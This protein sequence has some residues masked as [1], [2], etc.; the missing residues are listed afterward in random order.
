MKD[1]E[2]EQITDPSK[3]PQVIHGTY[4]NKWGS[5]SKLLFLKN[6][7]RLIIKMN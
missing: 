5:I 2:L 4:S 6:F 1:L 3:I 7:D